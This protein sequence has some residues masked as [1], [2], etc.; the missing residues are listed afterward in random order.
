MTP[1]Y[2][3]GEP[4]PAQTE[5]VETSVPAG[6]PIRLLGIVVEKVGTPRGDGSP[7]SALYRVPIKLS[8]RPSPLWSELFVQSWDHP[9]K[10]TTMH[11]PGIGSVIGDWVVLDGTTVDEVAR[12]HKDTLMAVVDEVNRREADLLQVQKRE[13][14]RA[15]E[16]VARHEREVRQVADHLSFDRE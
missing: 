10:F 14:D 11:R 8:R 12:F 5:R 13:A 4:Y 16:E 7:G 6:E 9:P 2:K 1:E 3:D 15:A